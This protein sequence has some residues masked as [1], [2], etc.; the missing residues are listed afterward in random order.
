MVDYIDDDGDGDPDEMDIRYFVDGSLR[1][2]WFGIDLDDDSAMWSLTGYEY[3]GPSYFESDPYGENIFYMNKI[4]PNQGIWIP[5]SECPFSFHDTDGDGYSEVVVRVSAVPLEYDRNKHPDYANYQGSS[6]WQKEQ[7][8]MGVVN[9][10]YSFDID[11]LSSSENPLHY[12]FGF[13]LVGGI[14]YDFE[15]MEHFNLKRRPPQVTR[16][17]PYERIIEVSD[18][19][20]A[21]E[22][23][24]SWHEHY[25]D[26]ISIGYGPARDQDMRWEGIFWIWERRFMEN[27]GAPNQ[28]WN[29]RREWS[30]QPAEQRE[31]YY[32]GIDRRIHLKGAKEGWI[33]VGHFAGQGAI[34]E[35][36]ML[37]TN[38][39]GFFDRWEVYLGNETTPARVSTV[40]D[41]KVRLL[42]FDLQ[43][44]GDF[45]TQ[46][47]LP[48]AME[49]N[50]DL[51]AAMERVHKFNAPRG[52][53]KAL[54][55]GSDN[56]RRYVQDI[57]RELHY[58]SLR[59]RL[60][61]SAHEVLRNSQFNDLFSERQNPPNT[62]TAWRVI[63]LLQDLEVAYGNGD[64]D[65]AISIL[66]E[67]VPER[68]EATALNAEHGD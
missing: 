63:R 68:E 44:L 56:V 42:Q 24:F 38:D 59:S 52:L 23:G 55:E 27:T 45:Y 48:E 60:V 3:G 37:D 7:E 1:N 9:I 66:K 12:D 39:N 65:V 11:N 62:E 10:R 40:Q 22:T 64:F 14:P 67:L 33:E 8:Q 4:D 53:E 6:A 2:A 20:P 13:N 15:G 26:T 58:Q 61:G 31:L 5:I 46:E 57:I 54:E 43:S 21:R 35:V 25:D 34:G 16:F 18:S 50:D 29:V 36:R 32:S 47:V 49:A 51:M 28:K 41:E 30:Q 19:F 17:I